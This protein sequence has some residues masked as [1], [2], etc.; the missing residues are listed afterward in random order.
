MKLQLQDQSKTYLLNLLLKCAQLLPNPE[1]VASPAEI[2]LL[3]KQMIKN[4]PQLINL[5]NLILFSHE[6][7]S[8]VY[9]SIPEAPELEC[10]TVFCQKLLQNYIFI[11]ERQISFIQNLVADYRELVRFRARVA[12]F[13]GHQLQLANKNGQISIYDS[14][15][16]NGA[17][18]EKLQ[19]SLNQHGSRGGSSDLY[20][21]A[22]ELLLKATQC[23]IGV[24]PTGNSGLGQV[25]DTVLYSQGQS[26][27]SYLRQCVNQ[28]TAEAPRLLIRL[29]DEEAY[30]AFNVIIFVVNYFSRLFNTPSIQNMVAK[31]AELHM[32]V[33]TSK[34]LIANIRKNLGLQ[35]NASANKIIEAVQVLSTKA[36]EDAGF[37]DVLN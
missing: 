1:L 25:G 23:G 18:C 3:L 34:T 16:Q 4:S 26:R 28:A 33:S 30:Q 20:L 21:A 15:K 31:L 22:E 27:D 36:L 7:L 24:N 12:D 11:T 17:I 13:V 14:M 9:N 5:Q 37:G 8:N 6:K 10:Y 32:Y 2:P 35:S 29:T 19:L